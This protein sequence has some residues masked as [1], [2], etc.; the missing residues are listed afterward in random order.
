MTNAKTLI[1]ILVS[2]ANRV[3]SG[4]AVEHSPTDGIVCKVDDARVA[5]IP[6]T[7]EKADR[8]LSAP[9]EEQTK[10]L[11]ATIAYS[12]VLSQWGGAS[13]SPTSAEAVKE[14]RIEVPVEVVKTVEVVKEVR[15][16]V[17]VEVVKTIEVPQTDGNA[18]TITC[19]SIGDWIKEQVK[20]LKVKA[21][22]VDITDPFD[23]QKVVSDYSY[24]HDIA[25]KYQSISTGKYPT[26]EELCAIVGEERNFIENIVSKRTIDEALKFMRGFGV[27]DQELLM[28]LRTDN[29]SALRRNSPY[30]KRLEQAKA[31][32]LPTPEG[33]VGPTLRQRIE[34]ADAVIRK[35]KAMQKEKAKAEAEAVAQKEPVAPVEPVGI[36]ET[37]FTGE[38][39]AP[40]VPVKTA[41]APEVAVPKSFQDRTTEVVNN[42]YK[43]PREAIEAHNELCKEWKAH[44]E[45]TGLD[46]DEAVSR[47]G[48]DPTS[49][50]L[51][52]EMVKPFRYHC[53][54]M[55]QSF[56]SYSY[57][58]DPVKV[59][60]HHKT[61]KDVAIKAAEQVK[62]E[63]NIFT[64][65]DVFDYLLSIE[66]NV[67]RTAKLPTAVDAAPF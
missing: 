44:L 17:P 62:H 61:S 25:T 30:A 48:I 65:C 41:S 67:K 12:E 36:S 54:E 60:L 34:F 26:T 7:G 52:E 56:A 6:F 37:S 9:I 20:V 4:V 19:G 42:V 32:L 27:H 10:V 23:R 51:R 3:F 33:E 49:K 43:T 59:G 2:K 1:S 16:E 47:A 64:L 5:S 50:S 8:F 40:E 35:G 29:I 38:T 55:L 66:S 21:E 39:S 28:G 58:I 46:H 31:H 53:A 11:D 57:R 13:V 45:E 14:V 18:Q 63:L 22:A 24:L 15:V